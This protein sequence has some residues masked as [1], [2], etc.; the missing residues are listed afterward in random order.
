MYA[1]RGADKAAEFEL[2]AASP[3][4]IAGRMEDVRRRF[5]YGLSIVTA[6]WVRPRMMGETTQLFSM[7]ALSGRNVWS[8][9]WP[10]AVTTSTASGPI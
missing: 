10:Q 2:K 6:T 1:E 8:L 5:E 4:D 3:E 7:V 9:S